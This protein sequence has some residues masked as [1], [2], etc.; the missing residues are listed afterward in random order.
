MA[1]AVILTL[2]TGCGGSSARPISSVSPKPVI[3]SPSPVSANVSIPKCTAGQTVTSADELKQAMASATPGAVILMAPGTYSGHIVAKV[4]GTS[5]SPI[6]LCGTRDSILDGGSTKTGYALHLDGASWWRLIGFT[7]EGGQ[8]GIVADHVDHDLIS[9]LYVHDIGD[10]AIHLRAFST[11]NIVEGVTIRNT[12][13]ESSKF[14][15]GIYV[16]TAHSNWCRYTSCQPDLSDRNVIR[17][18]DIANTTAENIDIK[19]GTTGGLI[20]GNKLSGDGMDATAATAWV[21]VK[22]N[23]WTITGNIGQRSLKDG[24]QVHRVYAGWG[25]DNVFR[26]NRAA[27]DGPGYGFYIQSASLSAVVACDNTATG[28]AMGLSNRPCTSA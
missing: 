10:E 2:A 19:E 4:S 8:K 17:D 5:S 25:M 12:G 23:G 16:G 20:A 14:G 9:G 22:G 7:V 15:E 13:L 24:F 3:V 11:D 1:G 28:A 6:S 27:V 18:N 21:N 26:L